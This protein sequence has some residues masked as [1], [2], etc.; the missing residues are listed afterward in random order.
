M[1]DAAACST[2]QP[3]TPRVTLDALCNLQ[4]TLIVI[5]FRPDSS[6]D[7]TLAEHN[8]EELEDQDGGDTAA[9]R[10]G[11]RKRCYREPG[12]GGGTC[13]GDSACA[14]LSGGREYDTGGSQ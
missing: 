14:P 1:L 6:G 4:E 11:I 5:G 7:D 8:N 2:M 13:G 10:N 3:G 12:P 9:T